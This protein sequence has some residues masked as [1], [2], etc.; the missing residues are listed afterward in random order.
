VADDGAVEHDRHI[1]AGL[2][3]PR[4]PVTIRSRIGINLNLVVDQVNDPIDRDAVGA[5]RFVRTPVSTSF[6]YWSIEM[7][8]SG[9]AVGCTD[10]VIVDMVIYSLEPVVLTRGRMMRHWC[11]TPPLAFI[12]YLCTLISLLKQVSKGDVCKVEAS[13]ADGKSI[14]GGDRKRRRGFL[15]PSHFPRR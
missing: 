11:R 2:V 10:R 9:P 4:W 6:S 1:F 12:R 5:T 15:S 3:D 14:A 7:G 8:P 13:P